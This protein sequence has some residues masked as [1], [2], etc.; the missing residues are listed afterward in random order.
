MP[1]SRTTTSRETNLV[2]ELKTTGSLLY[3]KPD[4]TRNVLTEA[5]LDA[6]RSRFETSLRE[7]LFIVKFDGCLEELG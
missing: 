2:T 4:R 5:K 7:S 6:I 3:K 1:V